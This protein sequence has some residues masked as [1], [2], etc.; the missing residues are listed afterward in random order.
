[1][2][3]RAA[4]YFLRSYLYK[5]CLAVTIIVSVIAFSSIVTLASIFYY[6]IDPIIPLALLAIFWA[7]II[8]IIYFCHRFAEQQFNIEVS[9]ML[10]FCNKFKLIFILLGGLKKLF[11]S[12]SK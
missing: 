3:E 6:H 2:M 8:G 11:S 1:M 4:K 9:R 12:K 5:I 10:T 7:L